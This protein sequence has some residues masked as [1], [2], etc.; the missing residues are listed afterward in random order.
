MCNLKGDVRRR[1]RNSITWVFITS[2]DLPPP[3]PP[4][5]FLWYSRI[6]MYKNPS[7]NYLFAW[8]RSLRENRG[9]FLK[10]WVA[11]MNLILW[12]T[13]HLV[14]SI[15]VPAR[16]SVSVDGWHGPEYTKGSMVGK[17]IRTHQLYDKIM[18]NVFLL[19]KL[20]SAY[21]FLFAICF[22]C[23]FYNL[24]C[25]LL[26]SSCKHSSLF[27]NDIYYFSYKFTLNRSWRLTEERKCKQTTIPI[28]ISY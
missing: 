6:S 22:L 26:L 18:W 7:S 20:I 17:P 27:Y 15:L 24:S 10:L 16:M 11:S 9:I 2:L 21:F 28:S 1:A 5:C 4:L 19:T 23:I 8:N 25:W 3:S 12:N 13:A 14:T